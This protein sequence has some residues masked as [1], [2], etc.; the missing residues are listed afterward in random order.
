[1]GVLIL[2]RM[3]FIQ[4]VVEPGLHLVEALVGFKSSFLWIHKSLNLAHVDAVVPWKLAI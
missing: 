2:V 1:M 3:D 4:S